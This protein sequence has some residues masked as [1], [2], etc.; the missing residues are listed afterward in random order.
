MAKIQEGGQLGSLKNES[1]VTSI[2]VYCEENSTSISLS[3]NN[4]SLSYLTVEE[5]ITLRNEINSA[6][7]KF[8]GL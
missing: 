4:S 1:K 3:I 6:L 7:K 2:D 8:I 5:A